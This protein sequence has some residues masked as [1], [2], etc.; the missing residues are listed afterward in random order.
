VAP[1]RACRAHY[2]RRARRARSAWLLA[3]RRVAGWVAAGCMVAAAQAGSLPQ[4]CEAG[5]EPDAARQA[6][7]LRVAAAVRQELARHDAS[8][9]LVARAGLDLSLLGQRYSHAGLSLREHPGGPWTVRQLYFACDEGRPRIFDQGLAGFLAGNEGDSGPQL[10]VV[11]PGPEASAAL[12][13]AARDDA[14]ARRLLGAS[15]SANAHAFSVRHQNCNQWVAEL[16]AAAWGGVEP[17]GEAR[18]Q[19]QAWLRLRGFEPTVFSLAWPPL[20]PLAPFVRW[21]REDDHP[22]EDLQAW[23]YRVVMPQSLEKFMRQLEPR[24]RRLEFCLRDSRLVVR[25]GWESMQQ[26]CTPEPGDRVIELLAGPGDV[27]QL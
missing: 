3:V 6:Q 25:E 16:I 12:A 22:Q 11:L 13:Q 21:L 27:R 2:A 15:Y 17:G 10:V 26:D 23:R 18:A 7:A 14:L 24:A 19:A 4:T 20:R 5:T 1:A 8:A 9:A